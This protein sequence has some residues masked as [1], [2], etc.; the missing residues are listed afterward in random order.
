MLNFDFK[1]ESNFIW[2]GS[3]IDLMFYTNV[4]TNVIIN[5]NIK[6]RVVFSHLRI[7]ENEIITTKFLGEYL[8]Q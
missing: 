6:T 1:K 3:N 4:K 5:F 8:I 7:E 2:P